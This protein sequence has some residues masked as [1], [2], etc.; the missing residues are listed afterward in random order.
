[1][2]IIHGDR[3]ADVVSLNADHVELVKFNGRDD[4]NYVIVTGYLNALRRDTAKKVQTNWNKEEL[5]RS[6]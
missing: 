5:H 4:P 1:L 3:E 2:A 6:G